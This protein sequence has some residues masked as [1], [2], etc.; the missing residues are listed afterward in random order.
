[1]Q[2]IQITN[3]DF[4]YTDNFQFMTRLRVENE[5]I[6]VIDSTKLLGTIIFKDL[7]WDLNTA[8]LIKKANARMQ[9]LRKVASFSTPTE[10]LK[11]VYILFIRSILEHSATVWHS[12]LTQE[13]ID[14]L[15]RIIL[16]EKYKSYKQGLETLADRR[17]S[18]CLNFALKCVKH[19]KLSYMFHIKEKHIQ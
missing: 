18:S 8:S 17:E 3:N 2:H 12:S 6:E 9:L 15:E 16:Q 13:N 5:P 7:T 11:E 10:D 4:D 14:D 19:E 1:M